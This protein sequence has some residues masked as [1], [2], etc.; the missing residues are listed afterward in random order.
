MPKVSPLSQYKKLAD[1][2]GYTGDKLQPTDRQLAFIQEQIE[3]MKS[4]GNRLLIDATTTMVHLD[5][6]QD[7]ATKSA[8]EQQLSKY[9]NDLRST[10]DSLDAMLTL[11]TEL[12]AE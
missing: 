11:R 9:T 4:I 5:A 6:A 3:Q 8:Y 2:F 7:Q 1:K 10:S 12:E